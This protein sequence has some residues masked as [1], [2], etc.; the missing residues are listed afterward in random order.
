[1]LSVR[2]FE[3]LNYSI[4]DP[5][6]QSIQFVRILFCSDIRAY[7]EKTLNW[8]LVPN[9]WLCLNRPLKRYGKFQFIY[10][11]IDIE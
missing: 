2:V 9:Y 1:M 4:C 6:F 11:K 5:C 8:F 10:S 7:L 3:Y